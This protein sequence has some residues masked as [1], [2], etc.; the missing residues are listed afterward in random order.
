[1]SITLASVSYRRT[2]SHSRLLALLVM[3][4]MSAFPTISLD[5]GDFPYSQSSCRFPPDP[6]DHVVIKQL[7]RFRKANG[8]ANHGDENLHSS[9]GAAAIC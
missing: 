5:P 7:R 8:H 9:D 3:S 4:A 1:M 2:Q 6:S